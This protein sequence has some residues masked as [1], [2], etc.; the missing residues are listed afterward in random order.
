MGLQLRIGRQNRRPT[1]TGPGRRLLRSEEVLESP[2][3]FGPV[4]EALEPDGHP[5]KAELTAN[6]KDP[7]CIQHYNKWKELIAQWSATHEEA[8][9][10]V[11]MSSDSAKQKSH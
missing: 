5:C 8:D 1:L 10:A 6:V 3:T 11:V 9:K 7:W 2:K 4:C